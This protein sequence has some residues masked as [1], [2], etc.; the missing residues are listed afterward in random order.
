MARRK[1][2]KDTDIYPLGHVKSDFFEMQEMRQG[3]TYVT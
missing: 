1:E 2:Y 3:T